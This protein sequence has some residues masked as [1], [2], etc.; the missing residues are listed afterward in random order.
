MAS[1]K[2]PGAAQTSD[3]EKRIVVFFLWSLML[4]S[5]SILD[6]LWA[7]DCDCSWKMEH[8]NNWSSSGGG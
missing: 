1:L 8:G 4:I 6:R 5:H 2:G 3:G 7:P